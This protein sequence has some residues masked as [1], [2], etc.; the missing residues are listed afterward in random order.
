MLCLDIGYS[1]SY[2]IFTIFCFCF[3]KEHVMAR[4]KYYDPKESL[5]SVEWKL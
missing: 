2:F 4:N 1:D 5:T 3:P